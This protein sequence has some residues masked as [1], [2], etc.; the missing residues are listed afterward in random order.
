MHSICSPS[1]SL[2]MIAGSQRKL[3][4]IICSEALLL[5]SVRR[6]EF[7]VLKPFTPS[8]QLLLP[9]STRQ[10]LTSS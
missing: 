8:E 5:A 2:Q 1:K 9:S 7:L 3:S 6:P 10:V 4:G